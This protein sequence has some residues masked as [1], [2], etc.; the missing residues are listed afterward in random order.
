MKK[1]NKEKSKEKNKAEMPEFSFKQFTP[2]EDRI[3]E[4]AVNKYREALGAG[5]KLK[6]AYEA[7]AVAD[8]EL[9]AIIQAD[10]LKILIAE[11]HFAK[12][13]SLETVSAD[14]G[15]SLDLVKD[16][17]A[18]MLQEVGITAANQFGQQMEGLAQ[19]TND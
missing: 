8:A 6:E 19:G 5:K 18:R 15:I 1:K 12:R 3:Y 4:E 9:R 16:T 2:E 14:L 10:F 7:Y 13:E 11:R 17:F